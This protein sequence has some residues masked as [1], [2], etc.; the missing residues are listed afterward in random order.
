M[1]EEPREF[2]DDFLVLG[3]P[4]LLEAVQPPEGLPLSINR[5]SRRTEADPSLG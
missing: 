1:R 4:S 2:R 5:S 3:A